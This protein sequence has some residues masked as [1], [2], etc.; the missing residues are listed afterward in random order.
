MSITESDQKVIR[1][2]FM[3]AARE[4]L[5]EERA[6]VEGRIDERL[7]RI[8]EQLTDIGVRLSHVESAVAQLVKFDE[9]EKRLE[10]LERAAQH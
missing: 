3:D 5:K 10:R 1:D 7:G 2:M 9:L 8:E 6:V 4:L